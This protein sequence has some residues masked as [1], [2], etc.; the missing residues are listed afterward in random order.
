MKV[1]ARLLLTCVTGGL[2]IG[3]GPMISTSHAADTAMPTK[4]MPAAEP[5]P[6]WWFHGELEVGGRFFLNDPN[7][8][9][10]NSAGQ[11]SLAKYYEYRDLRPGPFGN[12][13]FATGTSDGLYQVD[14]W[15]KNVGYDDQRFDFSASKAGEHYFNFQWDQTPHLAST[16]AQTIYGGVGSNHLTL[17]PAVAASLLA[18]A[19]LSHFNTGSP[20]VQSIINANLHQTDVGIQRDTASAQYRWTPTDAWDINADY[21]YLKRT[22]TQAQGTIFN[23][24][25]TGIVAEAPVPVN[26]TTQNFGLNGEYAGTS[27]WGKKFNF[28]LAYNGSV[29][30]GDNSFDVDNPFFDAANPARG[31]Q[32]FAPNCST[33]GTGNG[34]D[35]LPAFGRMSLW[36]DNNANAF[37][38]TLGADL[39]GKSRYMGTA[40]Y[41]MMRQNEAYLPFTSNALLTPAGTTGMP[42][43]NGQPATSLA[44]LP[45]ASLNG[46]INTL[47]LNNVVTTQITSDLKTKFGYRY[48]DYNNETADQF[49]GQWVGTDEHIYPTSGS[50][51]IPKMSIA[52]SYTKQN[53]LAEVIWTPFRGLTT[54][55]Q[56][57][58]E[59]VSWTHNDAD[60]TTQNL[61]KLYAT[62]KANSWLTARG[63]WQFSERRYGTYTNEIQSSC[64]LN[65]PWNTGYRSPDLANRDQ[66]KSKFQVDVVVVPMLTVS[67]FAGL[68]YND[69]KTD[70]YGAAHELG[71]LKD[72]SWNAGVEVAIMPTTRTNILLSYTHES[73]KKHIVGG[74]GTLAAPSTMWDSN[75][76]D[77]VDTFTASL[78]QTL[79]EDKLDL[80]L[81]YAY[82]LAR[83]LFDTVPFFYA[84][85][86]Y[87][88]TNNPT[89]PNT[90]TSFQRF[91]AIATYKL[92]KEWLQRMGWKGEAAIKARYAWE[93]NSVNNWQIDSMQSYMFYT[94]T[95]N[96]STPT[97]I[98][99]AGDNPNYN[100]H[101]MA[102]SLILKW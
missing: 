42:N 88:A 64:C 59:R 39:P 30:R 68:Q 70:A 69:Y 96:P 35:C 87:S 73:A 36:P 49:F 21:S 97:M 52:T 77:Q 44:A 28:K 50:T 3:A 65:A 17:D 37:T 95:A 54:G 71:I 32:P 16:S 100:V 91:D 94:A 84:P 34:A 24:S 98:W 20:S 46:Q 56:Y 83:G 81:N 29:Y 89:Y 101:L 102:L 93:R 58:Y 2:V 47:L 80:K 31:P 4:A 15:G 33:P 63:S 60:E 66:N 55:A 22:G 82:S 25:S 6:F 78:R 61:G 79:I 86:T 23:N 67:P 5:V 90:K 38:S 57:G 26:D 18:A 10:I 7:R 43:I 8:N 99:M 1:R 40:S 92:E 45:Y 19:K 74:A 85:F 11:K 62:Y 14:V 76:D 12:F 13:H 48:Y 51:G 27:P 53:G 75:L 9:G 72:D 41:T